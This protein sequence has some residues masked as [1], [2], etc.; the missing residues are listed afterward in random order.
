MIRVRTALLLHVLLL[1]VWW[2]LMG[3]LEKVV[4]SRWLWVQPRRHTAISAAAAGV[5]RLLRRE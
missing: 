3:L 4:P 1:R 5:E 2:L